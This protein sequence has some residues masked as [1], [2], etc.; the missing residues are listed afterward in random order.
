MSKISL[1]PYQEQL[2]KDIYDSWSAG[3]KNVLVVSPTGSGKAFTLST[4]AHQLAYT[5]GLPVCIKVHRK[6]LV[7]QL[8]MSLGQLGVRHNIIAQKDTILEIIED[9]R[10]EYNTH[11]YDINS[12][13][14]VV[15]V[16]TLLSRASKY[17]EWGTRQRVWIL[18]EAAHQLKSNKWGKVTEILPNAIG[19][20]FTATPQRL[21]KKGLGRHA[22]G[23]F[24]TI[25]LGPT[26]RWLIDQ[27]FLS[28]YKVVV[29]KS[30]YRQFLKDDGSETKDFTHEAREYAS[31]HSHITGDVVD[32]YIKYLN[33][34]RA[35]VFADSIAAGKVMEENFRAKGIPAKLLTGD[36]PSRE[37]SQG[38]RDYREGKCKVLIN[39]DLFGEGFDVPGTDGVILA[40]PTKSLSLY[41]QMCGRAL[42][43][44]DGKPYAIIIDHVGNLGVGKKDGH[45]LPDRIRSWTLDNIVKKRENVNLIRICSNNECNAPF[46]RALHECPYCG[47]EDSKLKRVPGERTPQEELEIVD[48]DLELL[49][50]ETIRQLEIELKLEDPL[51]MQKRIGFAAGAIAG[52]AA[53][54]RQTER[55]EMQK[56]LSSTIA[57]WAGKMASHG[58]TNRQI[59]KKFYNEFGDTITVALS[60]NRADM[61][62]LKKEIEYSL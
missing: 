10:R 53:Y 15:S 6:E 51:E 2:I 62:R 50:P 36:T 52:K 32:N 55:I 21:D 8:C 13:V 31:L 14:T 3:H 57:L 38:V 5:Y 12:P 33:D 60:F 45:G 19:V 58:F 54:N 1:R 35:I 17:Q 43:V 56:E 23:L 26:V 9:Q 48:G 59:K 34:R 30:D 46:D 42:R 29:P 49:D 20:G 61:E 18:D 44:L 39:V 37:R 27:R 24:D 41:L 25:V 22:F 28:K 40:R 11:F 47:H 7:S 4:L 16:D